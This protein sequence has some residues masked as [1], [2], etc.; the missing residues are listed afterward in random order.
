[1]YGSTLFPSNIQESLNA[2]YVFLDESSK[3][4]EEDQAVSL[5]IPEGNDWF[6]NLPVDVRRKIRKFGLRA[7]KLRVKHG[8]NSAHSGW[9]FNSYLSTL[10][11]LGEDISVPGKYETELGVQ[12][13]TQFVQFSQFSLG[14]NLNDSESVFFIALGPNAE[15]CLENIKEAENRF[16]PKMFDSDGYLIQ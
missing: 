8:L 9:L 16:N 15:Q 10:K 2:I 1:M 7:L 12:I 14:K 4:L 3:N 5:E 11:S 6:G 13:G